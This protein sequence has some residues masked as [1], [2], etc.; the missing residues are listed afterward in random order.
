MTGY[1][2]NDIDQTTKRSVRACTN[3]QQT[4]SILQSLLLIDKSPHIYRY[5]AVVMSH[6][7]TLNYSNV[8][9]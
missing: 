8:Y 2:S 5:N 7:L 9:D 6:Y 4:L 3:V 1:L